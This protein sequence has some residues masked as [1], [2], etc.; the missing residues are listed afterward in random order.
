MNTKCKLDKNVN[1][2]NG[3]KSMKIKATFIFKFNLMHKTN[4][5]LYLSGL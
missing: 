4:H 5:S 2:I 1:F 3:D